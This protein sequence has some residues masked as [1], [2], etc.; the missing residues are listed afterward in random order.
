MEEVELRK[1]L[2]AVRTKAGKGS[3]RK[4]EGREPWEGGLGINQAGQRLILDLGIR[5]SQ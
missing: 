4:S 1:G 2:S 3:A 5:S